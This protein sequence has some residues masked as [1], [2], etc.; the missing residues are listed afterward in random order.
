[1]LRAGHL[2]SLDWITI[3]KPDDGEA[4]CYASRRSGDFAP[5]QTA[6]TPSSLHNQ[7]DWSIISAGELNHRDRVHSCH[8]PALLQRIS[9]DLSAHRCHA[10]RASFSPIFAAGTGIG[11]NVGPA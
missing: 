5:C 8:Q 1:M 4:P 11:S 9:N 3:W 2:C 7:P 10:E 6:S